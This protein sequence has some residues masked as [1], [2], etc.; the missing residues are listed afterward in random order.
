V[1]EMERGPENKEAPSPAEKRP[2]ETPD[3]EKT[4]RALGDAAIKGA[5]G[6]RP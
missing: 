3:K 1:I 2:R 6:R 5:G 4:A